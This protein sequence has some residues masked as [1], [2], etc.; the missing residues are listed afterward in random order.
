MSDSTTSA[1]EKADLLIELG[2]EELPP[3]ALDA[4]RKAFFQA[5]SAGLEKNTIGFAAEDSCSYSS[6]RR[7][8]LY[9]SSVAAAQPDQD[10]ERRGP[11]VK[12][13]FDK[14]GQPTGAA[15]GFAR[16]VGKEISELETVETDKGQWLV[17]R[18][19]SSGKPLTELIFPIL[20]QAVR[21][22]PVPKPMRWADHDFSFVRPVHWLVVMHGD[23]VID[24]RLLGQESSNVT[25]G[26][27]IH[28]PGPHSLP[29]SSA[30]EAVLLEAHV[31][32]DQRKRKKYIRDILEQSDP[33]VHIDPDLLSEVNNLVEWPVPVC[34]SFEEEF[35]EVPHTALIA[36]M[37][38]HQ[39]FF[40]VLDAPG[41]EKVCNRFIAISNIESTHPPSVR[42]GYERVIRPR[43][44][45]AR[46]F[47]EQDKK[48]P[49]EEYLPLL[50]RVVFQNKIG[51]IGDKS[52]RMS[53]I[54]KRIAQ[55]LNIDSERALRAARL[56]KCDLMTQMVGEFPELQ[57]QMGQHYA[58]ASGEHETVAAAIGEHYS[59]R[60][61]GDS[62]PVSPCGKIVS[63]SDRLDTLV[64][65]FAAGQRPSGN[66]DPFA[67]R[68]SAL[69]LVR[70][71][72]EAD[73]DLSLNWL[74]ALAAEQLS[75]QQVI[76]P[77]LLR[78]V[79]NF[80]VDRLGNYYRDQ[81][82]GAELISAVLASDWD[83][84]PDL[85]R[86]LLAL[87]GFM[88]RE[89]AVSL[90]AANKRIGNILRKSEESLS[91]TIDAELFVFEEER[92][93]FEEI[94][95]LDRQVSPL[96]ENGDYARSLT[97]LAGL[98]G[99]VDSFFEA[100]MVMDEDAGLRSNRLALLAGLKGLFDRIADLSV[101]N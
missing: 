40:P 59:P 7:L 30:Y 87:A 21:Q 18:V 57:G 98:R 66:K 81:N 71:L 56:A 93:L 4:I 13:A 12:A 89:E 50:D 41:S 52:R 101:L 65:I 74:L 14:D 16:S 94:T 68:R 85:N 88:G 20:E 22:L 48:Q 45:D 78:D 64:G 86:R 28:A 95:L 83:T 3:K 100:V 39:K 97:L 31:R 36:S 49:L 38:D 43:L 84:L 42:E 96:I 61:A 32:V 25:R 54:S 73:M 11:A 19:H 5:V 82:H 26:H 29:S 76:E 51:T 34:C 9:F 79:R 90:A 27:R 70:I 55:E 17:A 99:P 23:Q 33:L 10:L 24:G 46:F 2:C 60:F 92:L 69:G 47:L 1:L 67:L 77:E 58:A 62:I 72:I 15:V 6:P 91:K 8:A 35:L 63:I 37:Q 53:A 80:V 75:G 44:A